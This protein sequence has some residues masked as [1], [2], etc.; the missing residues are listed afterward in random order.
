MLLMGKYRLYINIY[1]KGWFHFSDR[2]SCLLRGVWSHAQITIVQIFTTAAL[3]PIMFHSSSL[4]VIIL[5]SFSTNICI[6][7]I[8]QYIRH[9]KTPMPV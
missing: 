4:L 6:N 7:A 2:I 1:F 8:K 9:V 5:Y 3:L